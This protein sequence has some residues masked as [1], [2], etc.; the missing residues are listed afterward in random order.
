MDTFKNYLFK[1]AGTSVV[2]ELV[3]NTDVAYPAMNRY[4]NNE[5]KMPATVVVA[6][7]EKYGFPLLDGLV[8]AGFITNQHALEEKRRYGLETM[9]DQDLASEILRRL[10]KVGHMS[11][12][13]LDAENQE[14]FDR[15]AKI[16]PVTPEPSE[17]DY[18]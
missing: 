4:L 16:R 14:D 5:R 18:S 2:T 6:M 11:S 12:F 10:E 17:E 7:S 9:S 8:A 13:N 15:A 3:R 1:Q